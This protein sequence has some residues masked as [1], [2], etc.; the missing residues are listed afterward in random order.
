M[1][2]V[3]LARKFEREKGRGGE[4]GEGERE[5]AKDARTRNIAEYGFNATRRKSNYLIRSH[6]R[7][8]IRV[9]TLAKPLAG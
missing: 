2:G 9:E 6:K 5:T 4:G 7:D 8:T 1:K 3:F